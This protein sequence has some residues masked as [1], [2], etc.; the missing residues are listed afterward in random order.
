MIKKIL[1]SMSVVLGTTFGV[2]AASSVT[3]SASE[4]ISPWMG[5]HARSQ[6]EKVLNDGNYVLFNRGKGPD[7]RLNEIWLNDTG[8]SVVIAYKRPKDDNYDG[9]KDVCVLNVTK[10]TVYNGELID[11]LSKSND[12]GTPL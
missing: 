12:K 8:M 7:G 6:F 11:L 2:V 3:E 1:L 9:I 10:D 4:A 5:C